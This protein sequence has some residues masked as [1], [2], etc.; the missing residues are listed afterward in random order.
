MDLT[1]VNRGLGQFHDYQVDI[2]CSCFRIKK[3]NIQ[4]GMS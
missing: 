4:T 1:V 3:K 2:M